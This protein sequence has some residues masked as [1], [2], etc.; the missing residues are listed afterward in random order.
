[1]H[2]HNNTTGEII[3]AGNVDLS[4]CDREVIH[5]PGLIQPH[6]VM[7]ALRPRDMVITQASE[8]RSDHVRRP[9]RG[10]GVHENCRPAGTKA[11]GLPSATRSAAPVTGWIV[12][13]CC[14]CACRRPHGRPGFDVIAHRADDVLILELEPVGAA[15]R[16]PLDPYTRLAESWRTC[17]FPRA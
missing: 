5:M 2:P 12:D 11:R 3:T 7:L 8:N 16:R 4:N 17:R 9:A 10:T 13:P 15:D 1:M 6:G 14:C